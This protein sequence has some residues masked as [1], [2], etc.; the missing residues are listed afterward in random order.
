MPCPTSHSQTEPLA[1]LS[2]QAPF[3]ASISVVNFLLLFAE[4]KY[5]R[6]SLNL[7]HPDNSFHQVSHPEYDHI[8]GLSPELITRCLVSNPIIPCQD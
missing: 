1:L 7:P 4:C 6:I 2:E 3:V 5:L 8:P